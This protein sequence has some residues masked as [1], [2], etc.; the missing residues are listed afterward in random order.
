MAIGD[1]RGSLLYRFSYILRKR[2]KNQKLC[3]CI[4]LVLVNFKFEE[5]KIYFQNE[6]PEI[7]YQKSDKGAELFSDFYT[8]LSAFK[9]VVLL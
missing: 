8:M 3:D 4:G 6:K 7:S 9:F 2:T 5:I 1:A